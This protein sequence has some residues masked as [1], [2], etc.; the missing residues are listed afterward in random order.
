MTRGHRQREDLRLARKEIA[1]LSRLL[2]SQGP[3]SP[4]SLGFQ[5]E[6]Q[7]ERWSWWWALTYSAAWRDGPRGPA[8]ARGWA[9]HGEAAAW[10]L[11]L[12]ISAPKYREALRLLLASAPDPHNPPPRP[13]AL[14]GRT[15]ASRWRFP[16]VLGAQLAALSGAVSRESHP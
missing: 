10:R 13:S 5:L 6:L 2:R 11:S 14:L 12:S 3:Y 16:W 1:A 4:E 7:G 15:V 9:E 8:T